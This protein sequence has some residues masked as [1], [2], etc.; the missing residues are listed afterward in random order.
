MKRIIKW[1]LIRLGNASLNLA[2]E[3]DKIDNSELFA[4][5]SKTNNKLEKFK[6]R[7]N[8]SNENAY[9]EYETI[10]KNKDIDIIFIGLPNTFHE[11]FCLKALEYNKHVLVE[12]PITINFESFLKN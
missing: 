4:I 10:F 5:A 9:S 3:F 1:G 6:N 8:I 2:E 12:K 11:Q 7:F